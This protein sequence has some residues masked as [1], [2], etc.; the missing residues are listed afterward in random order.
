MP[1]PH[2]GEKQ[3]DFIARYM[4]SNEANEHFP[5]VKQRA[6]VACSIFADWMTE[7]ANNEGNIEFYTCNL[8]DPSSIRRE[9]ISGRDY[10][11][12]PVVMMP[13]ECVMNDNLYTAEAT[14]NSVS[15]W[16]GRAFLVYHPN[17]KGSANTPHTF[18]TQQ[19]GIIFNA[20]IEDGFLKADVHIDIEKAMATNSGRKFIK[21]IE[22][23][24]HMDVSTGMKV[25]RRYSPGNYN[26]KPYTFVINSFEPDH[27]AVLPDKKG[28]SSWYDGA[29]F[30]RNELN[31]NGDKPKMKTEL[32]EKLVSE[33]II[34]ENQKKDY[35][36]VPDS[37]ADTMIVMNSDKKKAETKVAESMKKTDNV[38]NSDGKQKNQQP[39]NVL[40]DEQKT[41]IDY[42]QNK[43]KE[44]KDTEINHIL[45]MTDAYS[46][47]ELHGMEVN[48]LKKIYA[49]LRSVKPEHKESADFSVN[50][51]N[52]RQR[53]DHKAD[54][55][56]MMNGAK[57]QK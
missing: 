3:K 7:Q 20:R 26:G 12:A 41:L 36:D 57:E 4:A 2:K 9:H 31:N 11:I 32:L 54:L 43:M 21:Y 29:G 19:V 55:D 49:A 44:E 27:L 52:D 39:G 13:T 14:E 47:E 16:N 51:L 17:E 5:D 48:S 15:A 40:T 23:N 8:S 6:T 35:E 37:V 24:K 34:Q 28:A 18:N 38:E 42:A 22:K 25:S 30:N 53:D 50:A 46:K 45:G 10:Y 33:G 56:Y 1:F